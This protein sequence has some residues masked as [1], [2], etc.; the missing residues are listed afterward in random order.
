MP[1]ILLILASVLLG[2][3]AQVLLKIAVLKLGNISYSLIGLLKLITSI[4][5]WAGLFAFAS[6]FLLWL[7]VLAAVPLSYA[8]PMVSLSYVFVFLA[9]WLFLGEAQPPLRFVGLALIISGFFF[10]AFS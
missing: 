10:V 6:S 4:Y 5:I 2:A 8:Y 1:A 3:T 7:K 9:S